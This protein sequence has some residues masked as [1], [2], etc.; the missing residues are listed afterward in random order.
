MAVSTV[1]LKA[2]S[3]PSPT[4]YKPSSVSTRTKSQFFHGFPTRNVLTPVMRMI[5]S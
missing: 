2:F 4:P 1:A 5:D 3:V